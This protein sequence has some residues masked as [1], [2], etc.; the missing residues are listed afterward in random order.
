[1]QDLPHANHLCLF[2]LSK[3]CNLQL[4]YYPTP[5]ND[6]CAQLYSLDTEIVM[7]QSQFVYVMSSIKH[8]DFL[9]A[10]RIL[11]FPSRDHLY[12]TVSAGFTKGVFSFVRN[13]QKGRMTLKRLW[14]TAISHR[15]CSWSHVVKKESFGAGA[16]INE[17]HSSGAGA[18]AGAVSFLRR[19]R[20]P[21]Q[22]WGHGLLEKGRM[23]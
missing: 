10:K 18:G 17:N 6:D 15:G 8:H 16:I 23:C 20:N 1:M 5:R 13:G 19:L 22:K 3:V 12:V 4:Q 7:Q 11:A 2:T 9:P 14:F 21:E